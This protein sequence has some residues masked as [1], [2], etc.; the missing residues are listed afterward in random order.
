MFNSDSVVSKNSSEGKKNKKVLNPDELGVDDE[1]IKEFEKQFEPVPV[2]EEEPP[3]PRLSSSDMSIEMLNQHR[4]DFLRKYSKLKYLIV[5]DK[6]I[7]TS[8]VGYFMVNPVDNSSLLSKS[9]TFNL[10]F[11]RDLIYYR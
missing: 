4:I 2:I 10:S 6:S 11:L 7:T 3:K 5:F 9:F 1:E 8:E